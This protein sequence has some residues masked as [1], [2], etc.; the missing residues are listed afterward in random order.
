MCKCTGG[1]PSFAADDFDIVI[2]HG[3]TF[4]KI[5][6]ATLDGQVVDP[7]IAVEFDMLGALKVQGAQTL[8][9]HNLVIQTW[10]YLL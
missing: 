1:I 6:S 5:N 2:V 10:Y 9:L 3:T 8:H 4:P 7:E